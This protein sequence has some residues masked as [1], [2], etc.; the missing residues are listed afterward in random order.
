MTGF[1]P[2]KTEKL[3]FKGMNTSGT[4]QS[5]ASGINGAYPGA[6]SQVILIRDID[7]KRW[8]E[9]ME[10]AA[11]YLKSGNGI[12]YLSSKSDGEI[13]P[14]DLLLFY[15]PGGGGYGD[16][17]ERDSQRVKDDVQ[18]EDVSREWAQVQYGVVLNEK[19]EVDE[20]RTRKE[21]ERLV[22]QRM[23]KTK[24]KA[25]IRKQPGGEVLRR[26]GEYLELVEISKE[27]VIRCL[28]CKHV[29]C[30]E[31][32][33]PK[34]YALIREQAL[35]EAGPWVC[36]RW[37]GNSPNFLLLEHICPGCGVLFDTVESLRS[38]AGN[39]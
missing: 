17:L 36:R 24:G 33:N 31:K 8:L 15:P 2:Y 22:E 25:L 32:E 38:E 11:E 37:D 3:L 14:R 4:D 30:S 12:N 19:L 7:R 16:P 21:R 20:P 27:R 10:S 5:N 28:R 26:V 18:N 9:Q 39:P 13:G 35:G 34:D 23:K 29:Y 1:I 6:G